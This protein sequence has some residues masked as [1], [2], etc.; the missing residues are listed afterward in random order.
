MSPTDDR[1]DI[2]GDEPG[3]S[4][5]SGGEAGAFAG[6]D[7][8]SGSFGTP[9]DEPRRTAEREN[10]GGRER[11]DERDREVGRERGVGRGREAG[12]GREAG[13]EPEWEAGHSRE[14][15]PDRDVG[16]ERGRER[17]VGRGW[18]AGRPCQT[19]LG[20]EA[21]HPRET[22]S[23]REA[24]RDR[25]RSVGRE[26]EIDR[27]R[28]VGRGRETRHPREAHPAHDA[29]HTGEPDQVRVS[30]V[31]AEGVRGADPA[32]IPGKL[33]VAAVKLLPVADASVSL[34]SNGMPVQ[35]SST[36]ARAA[37]LADL[38]AT[39]GD[40][41]CTSAAK[42]RAAVLATDLT[43]GPDADRWPVFAQQATAAG[44]RAVYAL[45][46]GNDTVCV[47]TLDLYR[48]VPGGLTRRELR[49]AELVAGVMTV[50]LTALARGQENG[51][52][53]DDLWLSGLGRAHD[54]VYQ[55]VGMIM[56]QLGVD[57]D[58]AL[59]RLRADAFADSRT[60]LEV[61]HDVVWHLKRFDRD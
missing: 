21:D 14:A 37:H 20:C 33:C 24:G 44:V 22:R 60:A 36:S 40:G 57:S 13:R 3:L 10:R 61:A 50:A 1:G 35:I 27:E 23:D 38:Q 12:Q 48:D 32:E 26:P 29:G 5:G 15:R 7:N 30:D 47:G 54:E 55:A 59:A 46:L 11:R 58:E 17:E 52:E 42:T 49:I 8:V 31:L 19:G 56:V 45:P 28:E 53:D 25:E 43:S 39:L 16:R 51:P 18:E 41:P 9:G 4:P 6:P 34:R 2:H